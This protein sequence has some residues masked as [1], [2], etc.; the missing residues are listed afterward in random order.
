MKSKLAFTLF[1]V[2]MF[3]FPG[4]YTVLLVEDTP[5]SVEPAPPPQPDIENI[6]VYYPMLVP[7]HIPGHPQYIPPATYVSDSPTSTPPSSDERREIR[8][9]RGST[10]TNPAPAR[11]DENRNGTRDS[12]VKRSG[13]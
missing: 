13:R 7:E 10:D 12:G 1:L 3:L 4:C 9:G 2:T 8:T 5:T 11:S 6:P